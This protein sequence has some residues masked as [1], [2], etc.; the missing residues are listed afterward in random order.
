MKIPKIDIKNFGEV[1][2]K[3]YMHF[4]CKNVWE[5]YFAHAHFKNLKNQKTKV[6]TNLK[7]C[8]SKFSAGGNY[9]NMF[10]SCIN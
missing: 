2:S 3:S 6:M 5:K 10:A 8:A 4:T 7:T 9:I 1:I